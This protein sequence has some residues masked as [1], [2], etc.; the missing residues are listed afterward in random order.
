MTTS[1]AT[2]WRGPGARPA[3]RERFTWNRFL[4]S[5]IYPQ[6][7]HRIVPTLPGTVLISLSMGI[8]MA[9]YNSS[10]NILFLTLSLLLACLILS[11]LLSWLNLRAVSWRLVLPPAMRAGHDTLVGLELRNAKTLLPT[12]G[13]W[14]TL[15]AQS[16]EA[17]AKLRPETTFTARSADIKSALAA[18]EAAEIRGRL[19]LSD[20]LDPRGETRLDW[21]L[22]PRRRGR[23]RV[24][25]VAVGSLFPF[26]F[27]RK[28]IGV[29]LVT[30]AVVW[31]APIEYRR[32]A[33]AALYRQTGENRISRPGSGNDLIAV[34][35]YQTGDSH[36]LI[37]WKASARTQQLLVRQ[38]G[39]ETAD[40]LAV[41]ISTEAARWPRPEQFETLVSMAAMLSEDLFRAGRLLSVAIDAEAAQPVRGMRDL[42]S[43]LTRLALLEPSTAPAPAEPTSSRHRLTFVPDGP[44]GVSAM[45][46]AQRVASA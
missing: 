9:A 32:H 33:P 43:W 26:G 23:L 31:P 11:G 39:A 41:W 4:W 29:D 5:L 8:G 3:D 1:T 45:V 38:F 34:R 36:R 25:L 27:L 46:G 16:Q 44:R 19:A 17:A 30:E 21:V 15:R 28:E 7:V 12:Y 14:F 24:E 2:P 10:S 20:R 40:G 37:H 42:E 6:R 22:Q 18:A 13:L 35:R